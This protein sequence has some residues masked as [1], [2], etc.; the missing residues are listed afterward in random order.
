M[1]AGTSPIL[2]SIVPRR[3]ELTGGDQFN[4]GIKSTIRKSLAYGNGD[5]RIRLHFNLRPNHPPEGFPDFRKND[6]KSAL[7]RVYFREEI[8]PIFTH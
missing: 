5:F 2:W 8:Y 7:F 4:V 1:F 3:G 6:R